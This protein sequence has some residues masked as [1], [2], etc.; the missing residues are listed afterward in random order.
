[1]GV[2]EPLLQLPYASILLPIGVFVASAG[3]FCWMLRPARALV[4]DDV[5]EDTG[6]GLTTA[7]LM[8]PK[9]KDQRIA[10]RRQGNPVEV[11]VA[12]PDTKEAPVTA[13][14]RDR[15]LGG[16]RLSLFQELPVDT[17][18]AVRPVGAADLVPWVDIVVRSC[19]VSTEMPGQFEIGCEYVKAPP[20]S[21]QL[22]FG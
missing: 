7:K 6:V 1:M 9:L 12:T 20:Y 13:S 8:K 11:F 15:S 22:L 19:K 5:V 18:L 4:V 14:V 3:G 17:V 2:F 10:N 16:L 21:I